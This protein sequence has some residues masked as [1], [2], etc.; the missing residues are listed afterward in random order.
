MCP[1]RTLKRYHHRTSSQSHPGQ[2]LPSVWDPS[3]PLLNDGLSFFLRGT[4]NFAHDS[5]PDE[6]SSPLR[7]RTHDIR[8]IATSVL[9]WRN[10]PLFATLD[11]ARWRTQSVFANQY[12]T[13]IQRMEG[14][15]FPLGPFCSS[16]RGSEGR[17]LFSTTGLTLAGSSPL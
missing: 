12:M 5:L 6:C 17:V 16:W 3:K 11:E 2:V 15:V 8:G 1:V 9:Q 13:N 4:F 14:D 7:S 10:S